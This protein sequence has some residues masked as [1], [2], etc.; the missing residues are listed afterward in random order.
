MLLKQTWQQVWYTPSW[1]KDNERKEL[2][3]TADC[4]V[5]TLA[6]QKRRKK[7]TLSKQHPFST[8]TCFVFGDY[9]IIALVNFVW[10]LIYLNCFIVSKWSNHNLMA[11]RPEERQ[12][13]IAILM[14]CMYLTINIGQQQIAR[15]K[16]EGVCC[17]FSIWQ[18]CHIENQQLCVNMLFIDCIMERFDTIFT[19]TDPINYSHFLKKRSQSTFNRLGHCGQEAMETASHHDATVWAGFF[20]ALR[21]LLRRVI[22]LALNLHVA[23]SQFSLKRQACF[24]ATLA[25]GR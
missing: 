10:F 4:L 14:I 21:R 7:S 23:I 2:L 17:W 13:M 20:C 8:R 22:A 25:V 9:A 18:S 19:S 3:R 6:A 16:K 12:A 11:T 1:S 15:H 24:C 5:L